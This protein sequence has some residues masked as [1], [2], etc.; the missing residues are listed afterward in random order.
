[1]TLGLALSLVPKNGSYRSFDEIK[2][3]IKL[4]KNQPSSVPKL[5]WID[6]IELGYIRSYDL[7]RC[8]FKIEKY[9]EKSVQSI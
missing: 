5:G 3:K 8:L 4:Y 6:K 1:M 7:K 9:S 2:K